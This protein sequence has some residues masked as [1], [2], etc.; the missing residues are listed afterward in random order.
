[1]NEKRNIVYSHFIIFTMD[2]NLK[3]KIIFQEKN[4]FNKIY[5]NKINNKYYYYDENKNIIQ[6]NNSPT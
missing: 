5:L 6:I 1:M 2:E 4:T 3:P